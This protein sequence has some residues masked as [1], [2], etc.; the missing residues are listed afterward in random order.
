M[1][2]CPSCVEWIM[3]VATFWEYNS[4]SDIRVLTLTEPAVHKGER[5]VSL[6]LWH[7]GSDGGHEGVTGA[8]SWRTEVKDEVSEVPQRKWLPCCDRNCRV[9]PAEAENLRALVQSSQGKTAFFREQDPDE[10]F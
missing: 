9:S 4:E 10:L 7:K 6:V 5:Q 8:P 2:V 3:I 1:V